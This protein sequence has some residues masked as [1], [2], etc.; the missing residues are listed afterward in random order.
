[1]RT[2][3]ALLVAWSRAVRTHACPLNE[4]VSAVEDSDE[5]VQFVA[6]D[7]RRDARDVL[8]E[9][10][11]AP[12]RVELALPVPGDVRGLPGTGP[13]TAPA[14]D[15]GE[16]VVTS[17]SVLVP[18]VQAHGNEIEGYATYTYWHLHERTG[19]PTPVTATAG[20]AEADRHLRGAM[21]DAVDLLAD[22]EVA[23]WSPELA[24]AVADIRTQRR[25]GDDF[26]S[27]L[28][29]SYGP[30][31]RELL[32]RARVVDR[33]I[34]AAMSPETELLDAAGAMQRA[35]ALRGLQ[36]SVREAVCAAINEGDA[37]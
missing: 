17:E 7:Q 30:Q 26:A 23:R 34:N 21:N 29:R 9:L 10:A 2:R 25:G 27:A 28:P 4:A 5:L 33:I 6:G 12:G 22:I 36:T 3:A 37:P 1:V 11:A 24:E 18:I 19:P 13:W 15:A 20:L 35:Q 8:I 14:L 31:A 32:A 16:A